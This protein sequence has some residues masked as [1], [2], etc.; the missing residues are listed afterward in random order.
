MPKTDTIESKSALKDVLRWLTDHQQEMVHQV[1]EMVVRESPTHNKQ[2]CDALCEY[3]AQQFE[4]LGGRVKIHR[5]PKAG[6]H[7]LVDFSGSRGRKPVLL[8]GHYDTVYEL[9]TLATMPWREQNGR[10]H[11]PG[12]I[13]H[14]EWHRADHVRASRPAGSQGWTFTPGEGL[15]G[16]RRGGG[17]RQ[18]AY[19]DGE[20]G[21]AM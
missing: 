10:L 13:R 18:L 14:E 8:L 19:P 5:Q 11:G 4:A 20:D 17:Q 15:V 3:L 2:A 6:N 9:G 16:L 7:L 12:C 21:D 1:R